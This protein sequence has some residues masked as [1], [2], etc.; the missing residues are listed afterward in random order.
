MAIS[1]E[2]VENIARKAASE[3][4]EAQESC[5]VAGILL[6]REQDSYKKATPIIYPINLKGLVS[7]DD[8]KIPHSELAMHVEAAGK[9]L[10]AFALTGTQTGV[11]VYDSGE[12][13]CSVLFGLETELFKPPLI[14]KI[15][16]TWERR[17]PD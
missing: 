13:K 3:I 7:E 12:G 6:W 15:N 16:E 9:D 17:G 4:L 1:Q 14:K 11:A 10:I 8:L 5:V 2:E